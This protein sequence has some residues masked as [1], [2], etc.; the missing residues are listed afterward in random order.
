MLSANYTDFQHRIK[1]INVTRTLSFILPDYLADHIITITP[2]T[3]FPHLSL[4]IDP[5]PSDDTKFHRE[6]NLCTCQYY[7]QPC[8]LRNRYDI[9]EYRAN[10][11]SNTTLSII[12]LIDQ[13]INDNDIDLFLKLID[14]NNDKPRPKITILGYNNQSLSGGEASLDV[15]YA[16]AIARGVH[17]TFW[18][19]PNS[20]DPFSDFLFQL[21][22][23][24][25]PPNVISISYGF[26]E[27]SNDYTV[28]QKA[29]NQELQKAA[30]RGVT[31]IAAT[32]DSGVG[33]GKRSERVL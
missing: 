15:Q 27:T 33:G 3:I 26:S 9:H 29:I 14:Q 6:D 25:N 17:I 4:F 8:F 2:T 22:D 24:I 16:L 5:I 32:G 10:F 28:F 21:A 11:S 31:I 23:M 13:Y 12:G 1:N 18:S 19:V 20:N 7:T 30:A